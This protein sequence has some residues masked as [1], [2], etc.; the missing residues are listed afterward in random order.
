MDSALKLK[1][2]YD[3][4]I[5]LTDSEIGHMLASSELVRTL[6]EPLS[7]K[8]LSPIWRIIA[9]S[10]IPYSLRLDY[11]KKLADYVDENFA[12]EIGYSLTGKSNDLLPCYNAML[13]EAMSKLGQADRPSVKNAVEWIKNYQVFERNR[14]TTWL[15]S[16]IKKYGGCM[17]GTPCYIGIAKSVKA[18]SYYNLNAEKFDHEVDALINI[19]TN[20]LLDHHLFQRLSDQNPITTHILDIAYP[21]SYHLNIVELLE[22]A[23]LTENMNDIRVTDPLAEVNRKKT[24]NQDWKINSVYKADGY[25]SFDSRGLKGEWVSYLLGKYLGEKV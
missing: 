14:Y 16:G 8:S 17:K 21:P 12:T 9:L 3:K 4:G 13:I 1:M 6:T 24:K 19:G 15:G 25:I 23:Y 7:Y 11:T 20:Y 2:A 10:E 5:I 18:L 22:I